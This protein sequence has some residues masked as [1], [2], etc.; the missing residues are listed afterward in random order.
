MTSSSI[1]INAKN[2]N[3]I[4]VYLLLLLDVEEK[5]YVCTSRA[6]ASVQQKRMQKSVFH[7]SR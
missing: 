6:G 3:I 5:L 2:Y 4:Q 7:Q 1:I